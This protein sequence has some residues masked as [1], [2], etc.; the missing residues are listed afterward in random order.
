MT[1]VDT[2]GIAISVK[3]INAHFCDAIAEVPP[4][5]GC[6]PLFCKKVFN[7][8]RNPLRNFAAESP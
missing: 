2:N 5:D 3:L 1:P 8:D 7:H 6:A 4:H